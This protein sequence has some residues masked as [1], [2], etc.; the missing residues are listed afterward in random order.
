MERRGGGRG[1][2]G[3][4]AAPSAPAAA[5]RQLRQRPGSE[6]TEPPACERRKPP[7]PR[8][9]RTAE[10]GARGRWATPLSP[11]NEENEPDL[12]CAAGGS[13]SAKSAELRASSCDVRRSPRTCGDPGRS[14]KAVART[15]S[16]PPASG[17]EPRRAPAEIPDAAL[18]VGGRCRGQAWKAESWAASSGASPGG[19]RGHC[20]LERGE[21]R[22]PA[23]RCASAAM[24]RARPGT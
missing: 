19:V 17:C 18:E 11:P 5:G 22:M 15:A 1:S 9:R 20:R 13:C 2:R 21:I 8:L 16:A 24:S 4:A 3:D 10:A 14:S 6:P 7:R 12:R 23:R